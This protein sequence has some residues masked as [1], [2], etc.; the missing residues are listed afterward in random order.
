ML[1][2]LTR[3]SVFLVLAVLIPVSTPVA[4]D[5]VAL[6]TSIFRLK[7]PPGWKEETLDSKSPPIRLRGPGSEILLITVA[8]PAPGDANA[9]RMADTKQLAEFWKERM[10]QALT[11]ATSDMT[12]ME[13]FTQRTMQGLPLFTV[14][15]QKD[16]ER[17]AFFSGY[18][19]VGHG[20]AVLFITVEG[21]LKN[22]STAEAAVESMIRNIVWKQI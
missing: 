14:R 5:D 20:G 10:R 8:M 19:L 2:R 3:L 1:H 9:R 6:E 13:P 21:W 4:A 12:I 11:E 7:Y 18:G 15:A 16:G 22:R 17:S